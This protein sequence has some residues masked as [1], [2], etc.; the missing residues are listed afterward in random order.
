[1][2]EEAEQDKLNTIEEL[3]AEIEDKDKDIAAYKYILMEIYMVLPRKDC[4]AKVWRII[5][6]NDF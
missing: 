5:S 4:N 3:K 6:A 2:K 1:M